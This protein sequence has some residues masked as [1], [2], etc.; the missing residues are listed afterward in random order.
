MPSFNQTFSLSFSKSFYQQHVVGLLLSAYFLVFVY[1]ITGLDQWL[2]APYF[3]VAT[4]SFPLKHQVFLE[5]FMHLGLKYCMIFVAIASL[6]AGLQTNIHAASRAS[7]LSKFIGNNQKQFIWAFVGMVLSTSAV[8]FLKSVSMHGCPNDL[9]MY[10]GNLPLLG[11]FELL[12]K[13][14]AAGHCFPGGHASGGFALMAFYFAFRD[15]KPKF[16]GVMLLLALVLG[17][18]MGW[19]Q[20]M[21][22][23]HF[24]SHNLWTAWLVW[25]VL[26]VL[27][28]I[29]RQIEKN[30]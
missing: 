25:L 28:T 2:I 14:V 24:L 6:L 9:A 4:H 27:F 19:G 30:Q 26:L 15:A 1:P 5:K 17:F 13:D 23:E 8:S 18:S 22:G 7:F 29:K 3:D 16:S 21:R 10:G 12:P 20:M 11:L